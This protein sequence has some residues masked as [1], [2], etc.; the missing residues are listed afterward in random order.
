M[1][2][3]PDGVRTRHGLPAASRKFVLLWWKV[4]K[5][6][7]RVEGA[8]PPQRG[9]VDG[10]MPSL[11]ILYSSALGRTAA[12]V[13]QRGNVENLSNLYAGTVDSTYSRLA[14]VARTLEV[15]LDFA[16]TEV[17]SDLGA[18][19]SGHLSCVGGVLLAS[20]EAHLAGSTTRASRLVV[21]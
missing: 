4:T 21:L 7:S 2:R 14:A 18:I 15:G 8:V 1:H 12:V 5:S 3:P 20:A 9:S 13:G 17:V 11:L 10:L 16:E 19:L 6:E